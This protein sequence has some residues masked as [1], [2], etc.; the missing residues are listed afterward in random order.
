M[1]NGTPTREKRVVIVGAGKVGCELAARVA[2][3]HQ[4]LLVDNRVE[5]LEGKG[6]PREAD[7]ALEELGNNPGT[8]CVRADGTSRLVL[9]KLFADDWP[10]ALV[11]ATGS[12]D[13][14]IESGRLALE[15]GFS[16]VIGLSHDEAKV[17]VYRQARMIPLDRARLLADEVERV[18]HYQGAIVPAGIGFGR[19][20]LVEIRLTRSSPI[21]HMPLQALALHQWR[22]AAIFRGEELIVPTG[23]STLEVDDRV[24]LVGDPK[25]LARVTEYLRRGTPQF[26]QPFGPNVVVLDYS[27]DA[28]GLLEE[29]RRLACRCHV[30]H[31]GRGLV[32]ADVDDKPG[33]VDED[34]LTCPIGEC[35]VTLHTFR[36]PPVGHPDLAA[37]LARQRPG[38]VFVTPLKDRPAARQIGLVG[39]NGRLC[40]TVRAPII[41]GRGSVPYRRILL[42]VSAST[43]NLQSAEMAI[44]LSRRLGGTLTAV[45]VD[46]PRYISGLSE[47][48]VH[49]EVVPI[50]RLAE[51][52]EVPLE[53]RH[54][55][56]NPIKCLLNE[57]EKA[58]LVVVVRRYGR[59]DSFFNPDVALRVARG[60]TCSVAVLTVGHPE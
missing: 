36:L 19:G 16:P 8:V 37:R 51:L 3:R 41:F 49:G 43:V 30:T 29:A 48:D 22:V 9:Q 1:E 7:E 4:V 46:L 50:R 35:D 6:P 11:A 28:E 39:P 31:L 26:P 13:A 18:L 32:G 33:E 27:E 5:C 25:I 56:G 44:D 45:N 10:C 15:I 34:P 21:L 12:D 47:E 57:A 60:A 14:N 17:E 42:P 58:D 59:R 53:Y 38:V 55:R 24:L 2:T 40:D 54:H 20:E 23:T 52:Y